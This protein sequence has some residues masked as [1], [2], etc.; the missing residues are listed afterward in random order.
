MAACASS[1]FMTEVPKQDELTGCKDNSIQTGRECV[2]M[3]L[4][5]LWNILRM[6]WLIKDVPKGILL[7]RFSKTPNHGSTW[8]SP[9][10][11]VVCMISSLSTACFVWFIGFVSQSSKDDRTRFEPRMIYQSCLVLHMSQV[12]SQMTEAYSIK[13]LWRSIC[14]MEVPRRRNPGR[15]VSPHTGCQ[16]HI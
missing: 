9:I 2:V 5:L 13:C 3:N 8:R 15:A 12:Y 4:C 14:G 16:R 7:T 1:A 11:S 6:Q 10:F